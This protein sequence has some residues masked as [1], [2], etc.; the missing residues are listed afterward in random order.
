MKNYRLKGRIIE[1]YGSI[2]EFAKAV[3]IC[4][5]TMSFLLNG[6]AVW[7][8]DKMEA[9][10]KLLGIAND[11]IAFYFFPESLGDSETSECTK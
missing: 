9:A 3:N 7:R 10:I 11:E 4:Q 1:R 6:K 5:S 8:S 2:R